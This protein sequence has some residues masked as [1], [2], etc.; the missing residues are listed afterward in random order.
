MAEKRYYLACLD[1][2]GRSCLVVGGAE[3]ALEKA[4]GLSE[5][6]AHVAVVAPE[7]L[8]ALR[9]IADELHE[10]PYRT[11]DLDG[12]FLV[13]AATSSPELD[14]RVSADAEA[15]S[16]P[17]NVVDRPE[18]C[19]FILPAVLRRDPIAVAVSTGG[20]SPALAQRLR[21]EIAAIVTEEHAELA[22]RL[23]ELRPW[24][25]ERFATYEER[26]AF[27]ADLVARSLP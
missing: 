16:L 1:L 22:R 17:C 7:I 24:A 2:E 21:D 8:P 27:F 14:R 10:R 3:P 15:R 26:R 19:S 11:S 13:I 23:R 5:C 20:A 18:L 12:R 4:R 25:K 6:G 9:T